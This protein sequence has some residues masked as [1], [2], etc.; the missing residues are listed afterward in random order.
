MSKHEVQIQEPIIIEDPIEMDSVL[1]NNHAY[2]WRES[3][4]KNL[5][6]SIKISVENQIKSTMSAPLGFSKK[7]TLTPKLIK[8]WINMWNFT[9]EENNK[10]IFRQYPET[11]Q[12]YKYLDYVDLSIFKNYLFN[13][14]YIAFRDMPEEEIKDY[15]N[16]SIINDDMTVKLDFFKSNNKLYLMQK[17][18]TKKTEDDEVYYFDTTLPSVIKYTSNLD[19][20]ISNTFDNIGENYMKLQYYTKLGLW[21]KHIVNPSPNSI[22]PTVVISD[23]NGEVKEVYCCYN[24]QYI[25]G[26]IL[27]EM[28]PNILNENFEEEG[29]FSKRDMELLDMLSI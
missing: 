6:D 8:S 3:A 16:L 26:D 12:S 18:F 4:P 29:Y 20:E 25:N 9:L 15:L 10:P 21:V 17:T 19:I 11:K 1:S 2:F 23:L 5:S 27:K 7:P 14:E 24:N 28:K 13:H 22:I